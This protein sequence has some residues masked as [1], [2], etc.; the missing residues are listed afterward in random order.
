MARQTAPSGFTSLWPLKLSPEARDTSGS[1]SYPLFPSVPRLGPATLH[2]LH[3]F[4]PRQTK[5]T[6]LLRAPHFL[7]C[8][9]GRLTVIFMPALPPPT[10]HPVAPAKRLL[11]KRRTLV[12]LSSYIKN[13]IK[14]GS[15]LHSVYFFQW[16]YLLMKANKKKLQNEEF[17]NGKAA[18]RFNFFFQGRGLRDHMPSLL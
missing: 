4:L 8:P 6:S 3:V 18:Q 9:Q 12:S 10:P 13:V 7:S 11:A 1:Q 5:S 14:Y 16:F 17:H 15:K 2:P